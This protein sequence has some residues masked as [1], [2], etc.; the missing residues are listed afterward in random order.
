MG[1]LYPRDC[2]L[3]NGWWSIF[4]MEMEKEHSHTP[5]WELWQ[6]PVYIHNGLHLPLSGDI[7]SCCHCLFLLPWDVT[8][9]R[10]KAGESRPLH[11]RVEGS[12]AGRWCQPVASSPEHPTASGGTPGFLIR[13]V[14]ILLLRCLPINDPFAGMKIKYWLI[15]NFLL[16]LHLQ[17]AYFSYTQFTSFPCPAGRHTV[18]G[19]QGKLICR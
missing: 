2:L 9:V 11:R 7:L 3:E 15:H 5:K 19:F 17:F 10:S 8:L 6:L 12:L 18:D 4:P 14:V 1:L 16:F 13:Q